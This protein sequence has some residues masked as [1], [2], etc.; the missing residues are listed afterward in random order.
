MER[1]LELISANLGLI[2]VVGGF[3]LTFLAKLRKESGNGQNGRQRPKSNPMM[4]TFGGDT[5]RADRR[6][7]QASYPQQ[8]ASEPAERPQARTSD[9]REWSSDRRSDLTAPLSVS[10]S[11]MGD[12]YASGTGG[13][14]PADHI[15]GKD[16]ALSS[17]EAVRGMMWAEILGPPRAKKPFG[18]KNR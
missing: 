7:P 3:L 16:A 2:I 15:E 5:N 11:E 18:T 1:L 13:R 9:T 12:A 10:S 8:E 6:W 4:P 17:S 14:I